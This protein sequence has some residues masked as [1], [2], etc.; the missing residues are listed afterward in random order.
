[1][2]LGCF[3]LTWNGTY[4]LNLLKTGLY[5]EPKIAGFNA[6]SVK[7]EVSFQVNLDKL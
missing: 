7:V 4:M 5:E 2:V 3:A 1:V 6:F